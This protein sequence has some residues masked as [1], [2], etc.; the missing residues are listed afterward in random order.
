MFYVYGFSK[1]R[2]ELAGWIEDHTFP[3]MCALAQI[4]LF[5]DAPTVHHWKQEVWANFH[6]MRVLRSSKKL[7]SASFIF[8]NSWKINEG[9]VQNAIDWAISKE[10]FLEVRDDVDESE[11]SSMMKSYFY[12]LSNKLSKSPAVSTEDVYSAIDIIG[13]TKEETTKNEK[14]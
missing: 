11:L 5:S 4:Y 8:D 9:F 14:T 1:S 12:W 6:S 13:F 2:A 7:P 3:V 10:K